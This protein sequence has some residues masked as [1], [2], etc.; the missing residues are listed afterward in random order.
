[1]ELGGE[2][3]RQEGVSTAVEEVA[4]NDKEKK[5]KPAEVHVSTSPGS[6]VAPRSTPSEVFRPF[7]LS[8]W[9][10]Q[11]PLLFTRTWPSMLN[12]MT[13]M[14]DT[15]RVEEFVKDGTWVLRAELPGM[16]PDTDIDVNVVGDRLT[17][18]AEREQKSETED[19]DGYRSEFH[20]GSFDRSM[21][22][23]AGARAGEVSA[24]YED[25]VLEV[26]L[27]IETIE[28]TKIPVARKR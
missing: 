23:P 14:V 3:R 9:L 2:S 25:G 1:M 13:S 22:L 8:E 16:D 10:D 18:H 21:T 26:R 5:T 28:Q 17:I 12:Q 27:P 20:Y 7:E 15:M 11:F 19:A 24:S 4:M 6:G